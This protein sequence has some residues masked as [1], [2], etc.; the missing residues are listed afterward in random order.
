LGKN[1]KRN[2]SIMR[3]VHKTYMAE[4]EIEVLRE[5]NKKLKQEINQLKDLLDKH[6][7]IKTTRMDKEQQKE[8][9]VEI[10]EK[11]CNYYQIK[12]GQ[13]MS[14]YRGEEVTLARQMTMYL[15]KEKTELNG[16]EIAQI[17]NRDRTTVLHSISKI[18]GQL[19]NKF[20]DTIKK[21]V[22][23]LNVLI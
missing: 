9:A 14:K 4:L 2:K 15:T 17:F 23:N 20:D 22:F 11:V 6:L 12:Y 3:E 5:K 10:A 18:R 19:S 1:N 16:E 7:N 13:M 21:D 8:Y